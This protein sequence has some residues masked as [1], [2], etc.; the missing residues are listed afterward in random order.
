MTVIMVNPRILRWPIMGNPSRILRR[1]R[2][3]VNGPPPGPGLP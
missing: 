1:P 2:P 3:R